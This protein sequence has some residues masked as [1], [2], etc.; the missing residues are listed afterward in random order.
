MTVAMSWE[1][2]F[3]RKLVACDCK[4]S[5]VH[6]CRAGEE[7]PLV[8]QLRLHC[9]GCLAEAGPTREMAGVLLG[10]LLMRADCQLSMQRFASWATVQLQCTGPQAIFL[11]PGKGP[12]G[13]PLC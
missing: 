2:T 12:L 6:L 4:T 11:V 13:T 8:E 7:V 5:S 1:V 3:I 9:Q 10:R